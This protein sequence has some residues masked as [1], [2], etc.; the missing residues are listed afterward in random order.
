VKSAQMT[1]PQNTIVEGNARKKAR[2][3]ERE[4][5]NLWLC[6]M[7]ESSKVKHVNSVSS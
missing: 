5:E 6:R 7:N 3:R 4:R 1:F 2:E